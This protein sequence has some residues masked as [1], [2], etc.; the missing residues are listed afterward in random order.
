MPHHSR[1]L[2]ALTLIIGITVFSSQVA[3]TGNAKSYDEALGI[4]SKYVDVE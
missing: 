1:W 2:V 4:I 3:L